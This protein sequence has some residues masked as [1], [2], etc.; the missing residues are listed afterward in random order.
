[1][2]IVLLQAQGTVTEM[3]LKLLWNQLL[4]KLLNQLLNPLL[5]QFLKQFRNQF[6]QEKLVRDFISIVFNKIWHA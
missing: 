4:H 3:D 2:L 6:E 5:V 1:M